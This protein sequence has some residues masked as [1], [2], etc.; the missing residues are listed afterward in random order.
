MHHAVI[1]ATAPSYEPEELGG[2][3]GS[4]QSLSTSS[5]P[6]DQIQVLLHGSLEPL[7]SSEGSSS[8]SLVLGRSEPSL[9]ESLSL[10]RSDP[11]LLSLGRSESD[12]E[13]LLSDGGSLSLPDDSPTLGSSLALVRSL[14]EPS[15][16]DSLVDGGLDSE[17]DPLE[18]AATLVEPS[19][20]ESLSEVEVLVDRESDPES[21]PL[22]EFDPLPLTE[23]DL[24]LLSLPETL[25]E[26]D[27]ESLSE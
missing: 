1:P 23:P 12:A 10:G 25:A 3:P 22:L 14:S 13:P 17:S 9:L 24:L 18:D 6:H 16:S 11:S 4:S 21:L 7:L 20:T 27:A 5:Q 15:E 8:E 26:W 2:S 19:L